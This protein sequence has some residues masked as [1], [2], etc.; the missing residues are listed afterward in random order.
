MT[1]LVPEKTV[2]LHTAFSIVNHLG[3]ETLVWSYTRGLDQG[4]GYDNFRKLFMLELKAPEHMDRPHFDLDFKQLRQ[5]RNNYLYNNHPD[6]LYLF[7]A[8]SY[9][10]LYRFVYSYLYHGFSYGPHSP[11]LKQHLTQHNIT[12]RECLNI[13]CN[14]LLCSLSPSP[15]NWYRYFYRNYR[16]PYIWHRREHLVHFAFSFPC[17]RAIFASYSYV[18]RASKLYDYLSSSK[19]QSSVRVRC[20]GKSITYGG[21]RHGSTKPADPAVSSFCSFLQQLSNCTE[22]PGMAMRTQDLI[23][24]PIQ[25]AEDELYRDLLLEPTSLFGAVQTVGEG[26]PNRLLFVGWLGRDQES[27]RNEL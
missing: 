6:V 25:S 22:T 4:V 23:R 19:S 3:P 15:S 8:L 24:G 27:I 11:H 14:C 9:R 13:T 10:S 1:R 5:Y 20:D 21:P 18:I 26:N 16:R 12:C 2:E 17:I 7:P